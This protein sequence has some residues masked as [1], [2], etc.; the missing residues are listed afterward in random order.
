MENWWENKEL[1]DTQQRC[2]DAYDMK[3]VELL[4]EMS[5]SCF[6]KGQ[7]EKLNPAIRASY[8]Y[9]SATCLLNIIEFNFNELKGEDG[10]EELYERCLYLMRTARDLCQKAYANL[11]DNDI[12]QKAYLDGLFYPLHVNY[13]NVLSQTGRYVKSISTLQ[14][15]SESN[16]P[17]AVGNLALKIINYSYFDKSHQT[18]MLY[19]AYHLLSHILNDDVKFPEK[20]YARRSFEEHFKYIENSLGLEYLNEPYNLNDFLTPTEDDSN[21]ETKY[22]E[23][24]GYN[25]LSLNQLNDIYVEKEVAYDPLHLPAMT[26]DKE[27][28]K[29]PK[30]HGIFNL[31]K[32]EYVSARFWI[33]EGLTHKETHFSDRQVYLVNTFDYP[34]YGIRIEKMKAAYRGIYSIFDKI[35][36]FLNKYLDLGI[37][38]R[39]ISFHTLWYRKEKR[40]DIRRES[41]VTAIEN[42]FALNGLWWIYKDLRNKSVYKDKHIDPVLRKISEVRNAMEHKYLKIS[43]DF[44]ND[45]SLDRLDDFAYNISF[46]DFEEL[47]IA[48]LQLTREAIIQLTMVIQMEED[49]KS[50]NRSPDELIGELNLFEYDDDWKLG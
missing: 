32:Q 11:S 50:I 35:A 4:K 46:D 38:E 45:P 43:E 42:N 16:Y 6:E 49:I 29:T 15:I 22:R 14:S 27:S 2:D 47:T 28:T 48:L 20:E 13:A 19:K 17:M 26:V 41:V 7:E 30:Y 10:L 34:V 12:F 9:S 3:N 36:F 8:L 44:F 21:A 23:W 24:F 37:P 31:I 33:Y 18:I 25:R 40:K 1:K 39:L 5:N